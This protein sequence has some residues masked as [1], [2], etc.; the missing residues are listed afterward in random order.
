MSDKCDQVK[1][2]LEAECLLRPGMK[3]QPPVLYSVYRESCSRQNLDPMSR[4][5]F[6]D[7]LR[8]LGHR[9]LWLDIGVVQ[10]RGD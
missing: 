8:S 3:A 9:W 4:T 6:D 10:E 7:T 1:K 2:F 5:E